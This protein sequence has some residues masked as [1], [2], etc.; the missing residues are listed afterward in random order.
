MSTA[1]SHL[2]IDLGASSGR[3]VIGM[4]DGAAMGLEE[5]HRFTTPLAEDGPHLYWDAER[6]WAEI[7]TGIERAFATGRTIRSISVDSWAVDYV[8]L[9]ASGDPLRRPYSYRD[10]R[11]SGRLETAIRLAG[12]RETLYDRT[13]IQFLA[14]NTLPQV[15]ADIEDEPA[16]V[17]RT[18]TRLLIAEYFLYRLSGVMVAEATMAS[19][20]QLVDARTGEWAADLIAAIGDDL[21]R[22]PSIVAPGT[23]LG[24]LRPELVPAGMTAPVVLASCAHDTAAA[25]AAVPATGERPW[26]FISSGT[27]SLVGAERS[28]PVLTAAARDAGFTNEAG[29]D[30]TVRFLENRAGMWV[31]EECRRAWEPAGVHT[32]HAALFADAAR[33]ASPAATIDLNAPEFA[34]RGDMPAKVAGAC[35]ARGIE[36]PRS[37]AECTRLILES[38]AESH[39]AALDRLDVLTGERTEDVHVVGGG[40]RNTLLNQLTAD[41]SGRRVLAGPEEATVLGNLLV[42]AR[43]LGDLPAGITVREAARTSSRITEYSTRHTASAE[44]A[45]SL[46]H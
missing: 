15:V 23:V 25:V 35:I 33:L 26:A 20:T 32:S 11:T 42:Q 5:V 8:P 31:L 30:G 45:A 1:T 43:A 22:W 2:A 36:P 24:P 10:P 19:T 18:A 4:L 44:H 14:L 12:G 27:W 3:V 34:G 41:R 46:T 28:A 17:R 9:D 13:G 6:M 29:L 7:R 38:L 21:S 16:L 39:A 37:P 40:A